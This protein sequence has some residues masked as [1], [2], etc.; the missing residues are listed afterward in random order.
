M[1]KPGWV[2]TWIVLGV[3]AALPLGFAAYYQLTA[4]A[5]AE[6]LR[7]AEALENSRHYQV[8]AAMNA[9]ILALQSRRIAHAFGDAAGYEFVMC[10]NQPPTLEKNKAKCLKYDQYLKDEDEKEK[11]HPSW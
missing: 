9:E 2:L 5:R 4:K 1:K 11:R 8:I 3:I 6:E 10:K 7:E